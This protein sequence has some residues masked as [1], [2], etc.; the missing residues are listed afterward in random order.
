MCLGSTKDYDS[1]ICSETQHIQYNLKTIQQLE[2]YEEGLL[3]HISE[4]FDNQKEAFETLDMITRQTPCMKYKSPRPAAHWRAYS[5]NSNSMNTSTSLCDRDRDRDREREQPEVEASNSLGGSRG[6]QRYTPNNRNMYNKY[7]VFGGSAQTEDQRGK[8]GRTQIV[9]NRPQSLTRGRIALNRGTQPRSIKLK[10]SIGGHGRPAPTPQ[11]LRG[12][13]IT[14]MR[15]GVLHLGKA[16]QDI[17]LNSELPVP[18]EI[19]SKSPGNSRPPLPLPQ[20]IASNNV[21]LLI[22]PLDKGEGHRVGREGSHTPP[23]PTPNVPSREVRQL[24]SMDA[25]SNRYQVENKYSSNKYSNKSNTNKYNT[26]KSPHSPHSPN[27]PLKNI[28]VK[29]NLEGRFPRGCGGRENSHSITPTPPLSVDHERPRAPTGYR[30]KQEHSTGENTYICGRKKEERENPPEYPRIVNGEAYDAD[31]EDVEELRG[32]KNSTYHR[33]PPSPSKGEVDRDRDY[34]DRDY[35]DRDYRDRDYRDRDYRDY[36]DSTTT[37]HPHSHPHPHPQSKSPNRNSRE[38]ESVVCG[39]TSHNSQNSPHKSPS[40]TSTNSSSSSCNISNC[41]N[42][43]ASSTKELKYVPLYFPPEQIFPSTGGGLR[44]NRNQEIK[45]MDV[46]STPHESRE[47]IPTINPPP[48]LS[49]QRVKLI[50][51]TIDGVDTTIV[52]LIQPLGNSGDTLPEG[53]NNLGEELNSDINSPKD[54]TLDASPQ[55]FDSQAHPSNWAPLLHNQ[56]T[57]HNN[58]QSEIL[59]DNPISILH[60]QLLNPNPI[61]LENILHINQLYDNI[62]IADGK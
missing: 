12:G 2:E 34:R 20:W 27:E 31:M 39:E 46:E 8:E 10:E 13:C 40:H 6:Q 41:S 58:I 16:P 60:P 5:S 62:Q 24:R 32:V 61:T 50:K 55:T 43:S 25:T 51:E 14:P 47:K 35:R 56:N 38:S 42:N 18:R 59:C 37:T 52:E 54:T 15:A 17:R 23:Q 22:L 57:Q 1:R 45:I 48:S 21:P 11:R 29:Y 28:E 19:S 7:P 33:H 36:R 53:E 49:P 44:P 26:N 3:K 9:R 30:R 4:Q